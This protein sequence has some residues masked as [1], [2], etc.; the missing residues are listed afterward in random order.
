MSEYKGQS[1]IPL[2]RE[3]LYILTIIGG[4][5]IFR[6]TFKYNR[7]MNIVTVSNCNLAVV[8]TPTPTVIALGF[9]LCNL[10]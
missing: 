9:Q 5:D 8:I 7:I 3:S 10:Q 2:D 4:Y 1:L 6:Q